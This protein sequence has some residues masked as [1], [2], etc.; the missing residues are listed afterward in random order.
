MKFKSRTE[1]YE[2]VRELVNDG[3][4][5]EKWLID[6]K[7]EEGKTKARKILYMS[8]DNFEVDK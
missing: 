2:H 1:L 5:K 6:D 7:A 3:Y 8:F 4:L